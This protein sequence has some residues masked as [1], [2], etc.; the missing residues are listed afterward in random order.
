MT[1]GPV[2][3]D[4]AIVIVTYNSA[5]EIRACLEAA[6]DAGGQIIVVDNASQDG[7]VEAVRPY[8]VHLIANHEN[9]G[10]AGAVNQA[11]RET[12]AAFVLLLN[13]DAVISSPIDDLQTLCRDPS[14]GAVAGLL[15]DSSGKPQIGFTVRR[16]PSPLSLSFETLG[17]NR[18][19]PWNPVNWRFRCFDL[20]LDGILPLAVDQPAGAF[21]MFRRAT[22][23][24]LGGFDEQFYPL[25][26]EDVDFCAR[27]KQRNL[28]IFMVPKVIAKHTGSHSISNMPREI[29]AKYWYV[30]L[31][32][33][34][35]KHFSTPSR[36]LVSVSVLLG[37]LL[38][39]LGNLLSHQ[40]E[41]A[42]RTIWKDVSQMAVRSFSG[43]PI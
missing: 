33:Y 39:Y 23:E 21:L 36:K 38:R 34:A 3:D 6:L 20:V 18:L 16:L 8:P 37:A 28:G 7:T 11:I 26:F 17:L 24:T 15:T 5:S 1:Q 32:R 31:L 25:W 43:E 13:P 35:S 30:N 19:F 22:W 40:N 10:F 29:R 12:K 4:L 9:R 27:L 14:T 41:S 2:Q 42:R